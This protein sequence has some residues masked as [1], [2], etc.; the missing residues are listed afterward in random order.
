MHAFGI[1]RDPVRG[2]ILELLAAGAAWGPP[3]EALA[4]EIARGKH[5]RKWRG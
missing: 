3:L 4:I 2:R 5:A 1:L